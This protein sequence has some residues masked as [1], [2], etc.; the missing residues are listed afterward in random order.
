MLDRKVLEWEGLVSGTK[1]TVYKQQLYKLRNRLRDWEQSWQKLKQ[2]EEINRRV[3]VE[4][5]GSDGEHSKSGEWPTEAGMQ[6]QVPSVDP[7]PSTGVPTSPNIPSAPPQS[8]SGMCPGAYS[9][10]PQISLERTC[11]STFSG[12]M[13]DF[14]RWKAEWE[15]LEQLGNP[16]RTAGVTRFHLLA[17]LGDKVKKDLVLSSCATVHEMF[18]RL[19]NCFGNKAKIVQRI[20]EEVQGLPPGKTIELIQTVERAPS[21]LVILGEEDVVKNCWV[22][23]S[24]ES[25]LPS[26]LR[27]KW[28]AYKSELVNGFGWMDT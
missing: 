13:T 2:R 10:R 23:Q 19:D 20:S 22:A 11:L 24:L 17:S 15:E 21:N 27:E 1:T 14:Y 8:I 9:V 26:S 16:Q 12:D 3:E 7:V 6:P 5:T 18:S 4:E 25:K 28:I